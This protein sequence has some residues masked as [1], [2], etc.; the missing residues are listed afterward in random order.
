MI[1]G[2]RFLII[3]F[4][5]AFSSKSIIIAYIMHIG[6]SSKLVRSSA[7][8][9]SLMGPHYRSD[10]IGVDVSAGCSIAM[11]ETPRRSP[12]ILI[13]RA[14]SEDS[15]DGGSPLLRKPILANALPCDSIYYSF[16]CCSI[17]IILFISFW[18]RKILLP[19]EYSN[20]LRTIYIF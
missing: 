19:N 4:F 16:I 1:F 5:S 3:K 17:G 12:R 7:S 2:L 6:E 11:N 20:T 13:T 18:L 14:Y 9:A 8:A 15:Q 10:F